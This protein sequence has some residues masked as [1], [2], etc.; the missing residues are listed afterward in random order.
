WIQRHVLPLDLVRVAAA[1]VVVPVVATAV[2]LLGWLVLRWLPAADH[3][4]TFRADGRA[5]PVDHEALAG[6]AHGS[7][8]AEK[9]AVIA[10]LGMLSAEFIPGLDENAIQVGFGLAFMVIGNALIGARL[11]SRLPSRRTAVGDIAVACL[12]NAPIALSLIVAARWAHVPIPAA[13]ALGLVLV[14]SLLIGLYDRYL[15]AYREWL[16]D[17]SDG[18]SSGGRSLQGA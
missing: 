7:G 4:W 13:A 17:D 2:V 10:L 3:R 15:S 9:V 6:G 14:A 1:L 8:L 18:D 16:G 12:M 5:D 11:A